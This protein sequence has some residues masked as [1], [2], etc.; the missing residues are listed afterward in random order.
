M[1]L[2]ALKPGNP[3]MA[4]MRIKDIGGLSKEPL[5]LDR[6][7]FTSQGSNLFFLRTLGESC[8][9]A[10]HAGIDGRQAGKGF[11][12]HGLVA[13]D[14]FQILV[15][16]VVEL[17]GLMNFFPEEG[18]K[19]DQSG[20]KRNHQPAQEQPHNRDPFTESLGKKVAPYS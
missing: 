11:R 8:C 10:E 12:F 15:G 6:F 1:A 9:M 19:Y 3:N 4:P 14:A 7:S 13:T 17:N 5:P 16:L 20:E 18:T 2:L